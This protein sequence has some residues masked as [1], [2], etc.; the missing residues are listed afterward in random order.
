[1]ARTLVGEAAV[2]PPLPMEEWADTRET[3]QRFTQIAGK[4]RLGYCSF[5]NH[6]WNVT[7]YVSPRG[8]TTGPIPYGGR[9]FEITFDLI[10]HDLKIA[11]NSG[12]TFSF[13]LRDGMSVASFYRELLAGFGVLGM[14]IVLA[15]EPYEIGGERFDEDVTH[16]SYDR[17]YVE[18]YWRILVQLDSVFEELSGRFT[19]KVSLAHL[20]WHSFDFAVARFS[21][22][23]APDRED[24][25]KVTREAYSQEVIALGFWPGGRV[26]VR[27]RLLLLHRS[28]TR[29]ANRTAAAP[30]SRVLAAG[31]RVGVSRLRGGPQQRLPE[32]DPAGFRPER[33][34]SQ[35][36]NRGL[37]FESFPV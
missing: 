27:V 24:A 31:G 33:L 13:P 25:D 22:R 2:C 6:W 23:R 16:A 36:E 17:E 35:R 10:A 4:I 9:T 28:R 30:A 14:D 3:L 29:G 7:L 18:R 5:Q 20:F 37:G 11:T 8:L 15:P 34:R 19:G 1:M 21:G 32:A 26:N 12:G